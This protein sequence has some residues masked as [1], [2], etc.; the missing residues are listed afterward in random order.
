MKHPINDKSQKLSK[1]MKK[2]DYIKDLKDKELDAEDHL[3]EVPK[4]RANP[5]PKKP[6][7]NRLDSEKHLSKMKHLRTFENFDSK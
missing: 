5:D 4:F 7:N 2:Q 3:A 1:M 6:S